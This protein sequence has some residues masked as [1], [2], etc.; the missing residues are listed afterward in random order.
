M[1]RALALLLVLLFGAPAAQ[2]GD[3]QDF[4][5]E[6]KAGATVPG[7]I[8][9]TEADGRQVR[10][11]DVTGARPAI[12][13]LGYFHCPSLCSVVRDDL[14]D[15]LSH[16]GLEAGADYD[17]LVVSIDPTETPE[18]AANAKADDMDRYPAAGAARGWHFLCGNAAATGALAAAVGFKSRY[19]VHLKQFL[20]PAGLVVLTPQ[21]RVSG[22][23]LGVGY[24]AGDI[25]TAVT[26]ASTGGIAKA[27]LPLLL[28]CFHYDATT[29]RYSLAIVKI[30]RLAGILTILV[31]GG[32]V[33]LA[34][35]HG[36]R[37]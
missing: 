30:L 25:R 15:A 21:R 34:A 37:A 17:L 11:G 9:L 32:T 1:I 22:Y 6:Q 19:D 16:T 18:D 20:H 13:A 8:A 5:F 3:A 10:L 27:A 14:L 23:V 31:I 2:A 28:L 12:L 7:D 24:H 36:R 29:G 4:A 26:V 33:W 35:R